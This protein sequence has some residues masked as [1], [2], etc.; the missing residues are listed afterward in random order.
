M[1]EES[2]V[3][4]LEDTTS[5]QLPEEVNVKKRSF[6]YLENFPSPLILLLTSTASISGFM[7][8]YDTG[9]VSAAL[10][11]IGKDLGGSL[12][13]LRDKEVITSA[14]SLGALLGALTGGLLADLWGRKRV[15]LLS[16]LLFIVGGGTQVF[17]QDVDLMIWG[18]FIMGIGVGVGS[19]VAPLFISEL[20]PPQ[21]RGRLVVIN[22]LAITGGQLVA[23]L[24][25]ALLRNWRILIAIGCIPA[26]IQTLFFIYLPDTPR[27]Y[28]MKGYHDKAFQVLRRINPGISDAAIEDKILQINQQNKQSTLGLSPW[29][30]IWVNYIRI[31]RKASNLRALIIACSL[32]AIQQLTGLNALMYFASTIFQMVGFKNSNLVSMV[33]AGTNFIFTVIALFVI[34]RVGRRRILLWTLPIMALSLFLCSVCFHYISVDFDPDGQ[35]IIAPGTENVWGYFLILAFISVVASYALGIGNI[36]WQQSELF[37]QDVRGTGISI[38]TATNW[39]SCLIVSSSFLTAMKLVTPSGT[40]LIFSIIG[41][42]S[43]VLIAFI[44]PELSGLELEETQEILQ[45]GFNVKKSVQLSLQRQRTQ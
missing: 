25:G 16:N 11:S 24:M 19:L 36:P 6:E 32:Q 39:T 42:L 26:L 12:L 8:G 40:F 20:A 44:Y 18:R 43:V 17:S 28:L 38:S 13:T 1:N 23:Y 10:V 37:S 7:F 14:T 33:I 4:F 9:Y 31:H 34:D 35:P 30:S 27:F 5:S 41:V 2:T 29:R 22:C 15:I 3:P 45:D 21:F